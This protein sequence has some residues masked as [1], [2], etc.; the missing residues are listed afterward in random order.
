MPRIVATY[1]PSRWFPGAAVLRTAADLAHFLRDT[2][3]YPLFGKPFD[4]MYSVGSLRLDAYESASDRIRLHT[5]AWASVDEV[6]QELAR[7]AKRGYLF[8]EVKHPD[9]RLRIICGDRLACLRVVML[10]DRDGPEVFRALWKVPTGPHVADNFWRRGNMLA[11]VDLATGRLTRV[12]T[13]VGPD[14]RQVARHPDTDELIT[15]VAIPQWDR[16]KALCLGVA[17]LFPGLSMQAWDIAI[18]SEGPVVI[19][20]NVGG[21][22]TLPQLATGAGLLDDR[23]AKFLRG[24]HYAPK[25]KLTWAAQSVAPPS[26]LRLVSR[27]RRAW[28]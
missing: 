5:G 28:S 24:K 10:L 9:E 16:V 14:L 20:A 6:L 23:F 1:H 13:G 8:Q 17:P 21:D 15:G 12:V 18:C 27:M 7:Y 11:A 4:G 19:E 3:C 22:F 26:L 2:S 25:P